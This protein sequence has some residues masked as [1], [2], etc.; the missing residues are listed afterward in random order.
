MILSPS[1]LVLTNNHVVAGATSLTA[2]LVDSGRRYTARIVGTDSSADVA[3]LKLVSAAGLPTVRPGDSGKLHLGTAVVALGNA[4]GTGG[5]PTVTSGTITALNQTITA[6]DSGSGTTEVLHGML[7][8]NAPIQEGD[9]GGPLANATGQVIGMDTAANT[10]SLGGPGT[11]EGFAIP[12]NRALAIVRLMASGR[13]SSQIRLGQPAFLGIEIASTRSLSSSTATSPRQQLQQLKQAASSNGGAIDTSHGCL[14]GQVGNPVPAR[15]APLSS[16]TLV[17][18]VFCGAP[19]RAAGLVG[20]DVI[21]T[22]NGH[23][24]TSPASLT[25]LMLHYQPG[26][27]IWV[28]WVDTGGKHHTSTIRLAAG[29]AK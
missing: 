14:P 13:A 3:L 8:T 18:G 23:R 2:T 16:G 1:G 27:M 6:S 24:V 29:P 22:L 4:G 25:G 7:R 19:A 20:G 28:S 9:S 15:I 10:R 21:V 11:G 17:A 26:N 5:E 12:I